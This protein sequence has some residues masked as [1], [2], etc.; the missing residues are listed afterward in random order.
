MKP[1]MT[2][3][4][5]FVLAGCTTQR[6]VPLSSPQQG[7]TLTEATRVEDPPAPALAPP[8]DATLLPADSPDVQSALAQ[9][10]KTG[11]APIVE[12]KTAG[13]LRYPFGLSQP[14]VVCQPL[15]VCDI[16]L[17]PGEQILGTPVCGDGGKDGRW[18][19]D[20]FLSGPA[21]K[22]IP[23]V[24]VKP[25]DWHLAT[26]LTI[27]TDRRVYYIALVSKANAYI[28][29][30]GFYYPE[31]AVQKFTALR[32]DAQ[33][34]REQ[35]AATLPLLSLDQLDDRYTIEGT[36]AWRPTWVANDG[37]HT[38]V[39]LPL[40]GAH[41]DAPALFVQTPQGNAALVNYRVKGGYYVVD[42]VFDQAVLSW[43][44]GRDKQTVT[45]TRAQR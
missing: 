34:T 42:R 45:I 19:I 24:T 23:H 3:C 13:F 38:Y 1:R 22:R 4:L 10:L 26:N 16:E 12:K 20:G 32:Q 15:R 43:G 25:T 28:R 9:Y 36:P 29:R 11:K 35:T 33:V 44:A 17:E 7:Q 31:D 6:H 40:D 2:W 21:G 27:G 41:S 8:T 30:I 37:T 18:V 14:V 39:K 5:L